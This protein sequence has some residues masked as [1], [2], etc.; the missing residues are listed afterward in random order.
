MDLLADR[1]GSITAKSRSEVSSSVVSV[2]NHIASVLRSS[3]SSDKLI[4]ALRT[5]KSIASSASPE[6]E[7]TLTTLTPLLLNFERMREVLGAVLP[8]LSTL[9]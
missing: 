2:L 5:T 6:E 8:T 4:S 7:S 1:V 3:F 9:T